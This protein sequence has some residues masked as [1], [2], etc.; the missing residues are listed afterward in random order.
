[1]SYQIGFF[2]KDTK[3]AGDVVITTKPAPPAEAI[4][5][6]LAHLNALGYPM[7]NTVTELIR[8]LL[9]IKFEIDFKGGEN[10]P[11]ELRGADA[12]GGITRVGTHQ[13]RDFNLKK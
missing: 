1:M 6:C 4:K 7:R 8:E 5:R 11:A 9:Y 2:I 10:D 3:Q 12:R 13:A